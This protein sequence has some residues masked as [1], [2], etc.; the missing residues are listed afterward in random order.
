MFVVSKAMGLSTCTASFGMRPALSSA[1]AL[2]ASAASSSR[3]VEVW[4]GGGGAGR[5]A[6]VVGVA[7]PRWR[8]GGCRGGRRGGAGVGGGDGGAGVGAWGGR[9]GASASVPVGYG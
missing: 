3:V 4:A 9:S 8:V 5:A 6:R 1:L 7:G 2:P